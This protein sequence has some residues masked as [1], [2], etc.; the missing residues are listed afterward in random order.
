MGIN[1]RT[2]PFEAWKK[3]AVAIAIGRQHALRLA[4][5]SAQTCLGNHHFKSSISTL[6]PSLSFAISSVSAIVAQ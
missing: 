3:I 2:S 6:R 5:V 1:L 4:G